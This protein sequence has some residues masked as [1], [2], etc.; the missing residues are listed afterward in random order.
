MSNGLMNFEEIKREYSNDPHF[1][2]KF[3]LLSEQDIIGLHLFEGFLCF[4]LLN[5]LLFKGSILSIPL[6]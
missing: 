5:G 2:R 1:G 6:G 3:A 4:L